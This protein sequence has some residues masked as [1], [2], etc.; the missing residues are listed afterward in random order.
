MS[1]LIQKHL[2]KMRHLLP[3]LT[4][5]TGRIVRVQ[6]VSHSFF[7]PRTDHAKGPYSVGVGN[8]GAFV[9]LQNLTDD[10]EIIAANLT[11]QNLSSYTDASTSASVLAGYEAQK[12][13]LVNRYL[14]VGSAVMEF[15]FSASEGPVFA[16]LKPMSRGTI[17]IASN[18]AMVEP[19]IDFRTLSNPVDLDILI[20]ILLFARAFF[21]TPTMAQLGPV[22]MLPGSD[23]F[24]D[25]AITAVFRSLL[26][27]PSFF[28]P[29]C[30]AAMSPRSKGGV[31]GPDLLVYGVRRL[32]VV[33]ASIVPLIPGAHLCE[34]V[35][36][37]AEKVRQVSSFSPHL[38][39]HIVI[40]RWG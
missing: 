8:T 4:V 26:V 17:T 23:V 9:P 24:S 28:H 27:Q 20:R 16:L 39:P 35:Y 18:D 10:F 25:V 36:A 22:E 13:I 12:Q 2:Q 34:T 3:K 1:G 32:S 6:S 33:D 31:V 21:N 15:P 7:R 30:T 5:S 29:C 38:V 19:I 37:I 11:A 14:D 40:F